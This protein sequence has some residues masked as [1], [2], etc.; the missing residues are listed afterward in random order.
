MYLI[1]ERRERECVYVSAH[2]VVGEELKPESSERTDARTDGRTDGRVPCASNES[3]F[4]EAT[5]E[6][7]SSYRGGG[8]FKFVEENW[9]NFL[10]IFAEIF[11]A[12][13]RLEDLQIEQEMVK[14]NC[15]K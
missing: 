14:I 6:V 11:F 7:C 9:S 4:V 3:S 2:V 12:F 15:L 5:A 1:G 10:S 13:C 8:A